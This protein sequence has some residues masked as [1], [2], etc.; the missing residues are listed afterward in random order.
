MHQGN[1][2][3]SPC[4][5]VNYFRPFPSDDIQGA[6]AAKLAQCLGFNG[7]LSSTI[8]SSTARVSRMSSKKTAK[9]LGLQVVGHEGLESV[10]IDFPCSVDQV[11][12]ANADL[13]Y[14]G[15]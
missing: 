11:K 13:I 7:S 8:A 1:P 14:G 6:A 9:E 4:W 10:D 2:D 12:A 3:L 15:S 5:Q